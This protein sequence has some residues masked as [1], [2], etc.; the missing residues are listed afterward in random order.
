M[1]SELYEELLERKRR[2]RERLVARVEASSCEL[3]QVFGSCGK[4]PMGL[5]P[6]GLMRQEIYDDPHGIDAWDQDNALRCFI[7][8]V[9]SQVYAEI[10][11]SAPPHKPPTAKNYNAA[12]LPW[13]EYYSD[14]SN[15]G[16]SEV[17]SGLTSLGAKTIQK[18]GTTLSDNESVEP[19]IVK[20]I[21]AT[22]LVRQGEF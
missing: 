3:S 16:G 21:P 12:G 17:L 15:V 13:F 14:S 10:T 8:L 4:E 11:G 7:H 2:R 6:G 1:K 5:A 9:N 20:S 19:K 18:T 22:N